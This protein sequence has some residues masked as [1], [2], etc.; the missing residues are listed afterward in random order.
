[1]H[2]SVIPL[3]ELIGIAFILVTHH[4][5]YIKIIFNL[6]LEFCNYFIMFSDHLYLLVFDL[7]SKLFDEVFD[8]RVK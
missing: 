3:F 5:D 2:N 6:E 1:M 8:L 4:L 7:F